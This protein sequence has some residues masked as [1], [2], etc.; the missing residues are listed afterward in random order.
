MRF[1]IPA[2]CTICLCLA[3]NAAGQDWVPDY[4]F[5]WDNNT[6]INLNNPA[7]VSFWNGKLSVAELSF[8]KHNGGLRDIEEASDSWKIIAGTESYCRISDLIA[9]HGRLS[10]S[11]FQ[12]QKMGGPVLMDPDYNPVGF[13]ESDYSELSQGLKTRELYSLGGDIAITPWER[14]SFGAGVSYQAGDQVKSKDPRFSN[15]WMDLVVNAG[16]TFKAADFLTLGLSGSWRNTMENVKGHI[17]GTTDKQYF[18]YTDKGGFFGTMAELAGDYNYV[19]E[20]SYRPMINDWYGGALQ[21]VVADNYSNEFSFMKR[22]GYYGKKSSSTATFFE[23]D[24]IKA[25]YEGLFIIPAGSGLHRIALSAGYETLSNN[26]NLFKYDNPEGGNTVVNYTGQN[27][28][29]DRSTKRASLDWRW[30]GK[31]TSGHPAFVLGARGGW[32]SMSQSSI[33][34]PFWRKHAIS[35]AEAELYGSKSFFSGDNCFTVDASVSG[36]YGYGTKNQDGSYV[37]TT[38][39]VLRSFDQYLNMHYEFETAPRAG[40]TLGFTYTRQFGGKMA[41]LIRLSDSFTSLLAAPEYLEGANRNIIS[42][43]LGC[44]F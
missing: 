13:Y 22:A 42:I 3:A 27:H 29:L 28:I 9:F 37:Q 6:Y 20:S 2:I 33:I 32:D 17:Y 25:G 10:W 23:F 38:S 12:G 19:P 4:R 40:G 31:V 24:G 44:T 18:I 15:V 34:Y 43:S 11:D 14:W 8:D 41:F 26:E 1:R 21:I 30:C 7:A 5:V 39:T 36:L 16:V 35:H